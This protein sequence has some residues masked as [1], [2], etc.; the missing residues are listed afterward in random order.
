MGKILKIRLTLLNEVLGSQPSSPD[1][2]EDYIASKAPTDDLTAEE[3]AN[4]KAQNAEDKITVFY[5]QA[6]GTPMLLDYQVKGMFK[7]SC[8]M[9]AKAGTPAVRLARLSRRT[10]RLS[11]GCSLWSRANCRLSC[12][13]SRWITASDRCERLPRWASASVSQKARPSR[14]AAHWNLSFGYLIRRWK[15]W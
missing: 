9:L 3:V 14:R 4:I 6:D 15:R 12:T 10:S 11:T 7:D 1:I 2:H 5:K 13:A 8:K